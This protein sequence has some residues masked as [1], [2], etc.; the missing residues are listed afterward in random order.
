[1]AD[2]NGISSGGSHDQPTLFGG[3]DRLRICQRG[4]QTTVDGLG[5]RHQ[6]HDVL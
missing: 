1:M 5:D 3:F 2:E 6:V 4:Q